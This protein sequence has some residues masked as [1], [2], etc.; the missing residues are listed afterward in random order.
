[1]SGQDMH[2]ES[3]CSDSMGHPV[4]SIALEEGCSRIEAALW[5]LIAEGLGE[6]PAE[7]GAPVR[8][9]IGRY[10]RD[11]R[12]GEASAATLLGLLRQVHPRRSTGWQAWTTG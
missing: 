2:M 10:V 7:P 12:R 3:G 4:A 6:D 1:M 5:A 9:R 8:Q 11:R